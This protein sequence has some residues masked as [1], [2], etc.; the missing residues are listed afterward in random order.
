M[1]VLVDYIFNDDTR[2]SNPDGSVPIDLPSDTTVVEGPGQFYSQTLQ[3]AVRLGDI[4]AGSIQADV[5]EL[6]T[7][8]VTSFHV[9]VVF[10]FDDLSHRHQVL[11][12]SKR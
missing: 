5:S 8:Q 7:N 2:V 11:A 3:K 9:A 6:L 1:A 4:G 10:C 12:H